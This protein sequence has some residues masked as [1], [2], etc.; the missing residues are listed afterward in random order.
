MTYGRVVLKDGTFLTGTL[1]MTDGTR[2][3]EKD[4]RT[5]KSVTLTE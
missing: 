4:V 5:V 1:V 2:L 3:T